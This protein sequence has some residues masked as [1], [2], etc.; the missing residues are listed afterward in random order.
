[1]LRGAEAC[2]PRRISRHHGSLH[3]FG[4][5][6]CL[7]SLSGSKCVCGSLKSM[8]GDGLPVT[9]PFHLRDEDKSPSHLLHGSLLPKPL[10]HCRPEG[11]VTSELEGASVCSALSPPA[12]A[13]IEMGMMPR[14]E[15]SVACLVTE[16]L[17]HPSLLATDCGTVSRSGCAKQK[18]PCFS[19]TQAS[20]QG[21]THSCLGRGESTCAP[22]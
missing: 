8:S 6:L 17:P 20:E 18:C 7:S 16:L 5:F 13:D 11:T 9:W 12:S 2:T 19:E 22:F 15:R 1:M 14:T 10:A 4:T 3:F 21:R